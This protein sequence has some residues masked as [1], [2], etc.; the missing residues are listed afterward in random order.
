MAALTRSVRQFDSL[1]PEPQ[2]D[3]EEPMA[4]EL[5]NRVRESAASTQHVGLGTSQR[6]LSVAGGAGLLLGSVRRR[7]TSRAVLLAAGG[8]LLYRG[9]TGRC[10]LS[11]RLQTRNAVQRKS[12]QQQT[13]ADECELFTTHAG[14]L[15]A[16]RASADWQPPDDAD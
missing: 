1:P 13:A 5:L 4:M 8:Y 11:E 6:Y 15:T 16:E 10:P 7:P 12:A 3:Q 2:R 9:F 14:S